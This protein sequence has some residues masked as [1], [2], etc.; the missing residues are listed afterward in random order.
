MVSFERNPIA[1][2]FEQN[3]ELPIVL[4]PELWNGIRVDTVVPSVF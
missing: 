2:S 3:V 4:S 1:A